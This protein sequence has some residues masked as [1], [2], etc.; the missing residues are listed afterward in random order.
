[1]F[2]LTR[3]EAE[4]AA[5]SASESKRNTWIPE[6]RQELGKLSVVSEDLNHHIIF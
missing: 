2:P 3:E 6:F 1:M 4:E 5:K